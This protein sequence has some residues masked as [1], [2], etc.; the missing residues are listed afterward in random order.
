MCYNVTVLP[1]GMFIYC[2]NEDFICIN[3]RLSRYFPDT[4]LLIVFNLCEQI[5]QHLKVSLSHFCHRFVLAPA[6]LT[7]YFVYFTGRIQVQIFQHHIWDVCYHKTLY[8]PA[9][10]YIQKYF[11]QKS[12][13]HCV[14]VPQ[15][16]IVT[17]NLPT[18][19][20]FVH[21]LDF[22]LEYYKR[23]SF[24]T[25]CLPERITNFE[26]FGPFWYT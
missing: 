12:M 17:A 11:Y 6:V 8:K 18:C 7:D 20:M 21:V 25:K 2:F 14:L 23:V 10:K 9:K 19:F 13:R 1:F 22:N 26:L 16:Y 15:T 4:S 5:I 24:F 3:T